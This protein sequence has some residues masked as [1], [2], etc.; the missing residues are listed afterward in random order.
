MTQ[1]KC[2]LAANN[3]T[4]WQRVYN[5]ARKLPQ[6]DF[7]DSPPCSCNV[8]L[9]NVVRQRCIKTLYKRSCNMVKK[10]TIFFIFNHNIYEREDVILPLISHVNQS[11]RYVHSGFEQL[12][13]IKM[14]TKICVK[15]SLGC[16][17]GVLEVHL[18]FR[19]YSLMH[20]VKF[21]I[22]PSRSFI[23]MLHESD[24]WF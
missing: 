12:I 22:C 4:L 3:F 19:T 18:F 20:A 11:V 8:C 10:H 23:I 2:D 14:S 1:D 16:Y 21:K 24:S 7:V 17:F 6:R 13:V 9:I 5:I 15:P